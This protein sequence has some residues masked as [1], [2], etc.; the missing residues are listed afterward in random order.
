MLGLLACATI[1]CYYLQERK[2]RSEYIDQLTGSG[3]GM[4]I[5]HSGDSEG[6]GRRGSTGK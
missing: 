4:G 3:G 1:S 2:R 5:L 6:Y